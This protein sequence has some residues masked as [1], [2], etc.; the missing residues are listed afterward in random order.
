MKPTTRKAKAPPAP[1]PPKRPLMPPVEFD[2]DL[3]RLIAEADEQFA[4]GTKYSD[5]WCDIAGRLERV[6]S[7]VREMMTPAERG[8]KS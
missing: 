1:K 2:N 8:L 5:N 6:R 3:K 4:R 7:D